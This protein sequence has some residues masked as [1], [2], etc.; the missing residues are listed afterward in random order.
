MDAD[1]SAEAIQHSLFDVLVYR[2]LRAAMG[3]QLRFASS[4]GGPLGARLTHFFNGVGL[5]ILEGYGLTE[6]S[7]VLSTNAE[8]AWRV[9]TTGR[10]VAGTTIR[11]AEDGEIL[12]R[13]PQV[14]AGYWRNEVATDEVI[15]RDG[16]F[17]TGD[18]GE[19][20]DEGYLR[21]TGRKKE[22]IVTAGGK[23]VAPAQ[24]EDALRSH[25]LVSEAMVVGEGRPFIGA[26]IAVDEEAFAI[27]ATD[28][29]HMKGGVA[30][31][32]EA[33]DLRA[34]IQEAV[35]HANSLVS[36]AESIRKFVILP[37][38]L[39]IATGEL[40]PTLK[41]RRNVLAKQYSE[42]IEQIYR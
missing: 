41:V 6:T 12:A 24:L 20:D 42:E 11:I 34:E 38:D 40:T 23:N 22:I 18:I 2:K 32:V 37:N 31:F 14:F 27:W 30:D 15:D 19:L 13:G 39:S 28:A 4:G 29:G 7:P 17:H 36:R 10:P 3:G 35:D 33:A 16:W 21:I 26:L 5:K 25:P 8:G 9:G 1:L